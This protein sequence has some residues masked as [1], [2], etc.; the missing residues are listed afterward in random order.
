MKRR[1]LMKRL[2]KIAKAE[3]EDL[4]I[5]EGGPHTKVQIGDR[6]DSVPR[7]TEVNEITAQKIIRKM[8]GKA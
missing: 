5:T 2:A 4:I 1:D 6:V 3:D 8:E 7:H